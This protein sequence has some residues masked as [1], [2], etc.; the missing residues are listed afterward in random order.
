V[1]AAT[2]G[3]LNKSDMVMSTIQQLT[4]NGMVATTMATFLLTIC[5]VVIHIVV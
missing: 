1:V 4:K 5:M 2:V 3:Q